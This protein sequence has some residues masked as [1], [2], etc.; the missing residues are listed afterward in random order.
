MSYYDTASSF[1]IYMTNTCN[2]KCSYCF[3]TFTESPFYGEI[4][5][6]VL[7][8]LPNFISKL[9]SKRINIVFFGGEPTINWE[10][11]K[12]VYHTVKEANPDKK[13]N[14]I[15][16]TNG[17]LLDKYIDEIVEMKDLRIF[18]S[19]SPFKEAHD[20]FRIYKD[21]HGSWDKVKSN[22]D[23]LLSRGL[24]NRLAVVHTYSPHDAK[25]LYNVVLNLYDM[26]VREVRTSL[27]KEIRMTDEDLK[28]L[29]ESTIKI[30]DFSLKV[31]DFTYHKLG[32]FSVNNAEEAQKW[33]N[34]LRDGGEPYHCH[35]GKEKFFINTDG[36]VYIC[37]SLVD[38]KWIVGNI[39]TGE[40]RFG[41]AVKRLWENPKCYT[42]PSK[43]YCITCLH[44]NQLFTGTMKNT[45]EQFEEN[46]TLTHKAYVDY[47]F[48][49]LLEMGVVK[50][51]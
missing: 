39:L 4:K 33:Y 20:E 44:R 12:R 15:L 24:Q 37:A 9:K 32:V 2:L 22:I 48:G 43:S 19:F 18:V 21:N 31:K 35:A 49:K 1:V 34:A 10:S 40:T 16:Q 14:F 50:E 47:F 45:C 25:N 6:E 51:E 30:A 42:C 5:E 7:E 13:C 46:Y 38:P 41:G 3:A 8:E 26:G 23:L 28:D 27:I 29:Y 17:T 11:C 36:N